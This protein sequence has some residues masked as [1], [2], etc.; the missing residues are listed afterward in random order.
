MN[1]IH[2]ATLLL[3]LD[4]EIRLRAAQ[5]QVSGIPGAPYSAQA[6]AAS[7]RAWALDSRK[8]QPVCQQAVKFSS[9]VPS[10]VSAQQRQNR[11]TRCALKL[12][13]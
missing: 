2:S 10:S 9:H 4:T 12:W 6:P 11:L 3:V 8:R 5:L 7:E 13:L 1:L